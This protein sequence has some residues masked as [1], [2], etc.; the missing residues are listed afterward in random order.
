[1]RWLPSFLGLSLLAAGS[2]AA[3]ESTEERYN[4]FHTKA[5]ASSP[6]KLTDSTY[7]SITSAPRDYSAVVL[8]T[9]LDPRYKCQLCREFQPEWDLLAKSWSKGDKDGASRMIFGTLDFSDGRETFVAVC[10]ISGSPDP[11]FAN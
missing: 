6:V 9:A 7:K 2:I 3:K 11:T 1:M 10:D 8:L 5:L 4:R